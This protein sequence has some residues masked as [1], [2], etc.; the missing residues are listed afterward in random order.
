M[1]LP[2][3]LPEGDTAKYFARL[4]CPGLESVEIFTLCLPLTSSTYFTAK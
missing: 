4:V 1:T 3:H 2:T